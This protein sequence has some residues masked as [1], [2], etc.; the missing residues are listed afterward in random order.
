MTVGE[1]ISREIARWTVTLVSS[2]FAIIQFTA[3]FLSLGLATVGATQPNRR[4][5]ALGAL[6]SLPVTWQLAQPNLWCQGPTGWDWLVPIAS[7][8]LPM[9]VVLFAVEQTR[10]VSIG[11][12]GLWTLL[13]LYFLT[14]RMCLLRF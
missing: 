5:A 9:A 1:W 11:S 12:V 7:L 10:S 14:Q 8:I 13:W 3:P 4:I 2:V 6:F